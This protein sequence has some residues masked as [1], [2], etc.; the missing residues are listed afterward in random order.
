MVILDFEIDEEELKNSLEEGV[1]NEKTVCFVS[2]MF[3]MPLRMRLNELEIFG[4]NEDYWSPGPIMDLATSGLTIIKELR[5][6]RKE[7]YE[8]IEG[9]GDFIFTMI[10]DED[11]YVKFS[12]ESGKKYATTV[13]YD[14]ILEAFEKFTEKVRKFLWERVPQINNHPYWGPWLRGDRE[15]K[16]GL[17]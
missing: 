4:T 15:W 11:V 7:D 10:S 1:E 2:T 13:K 16:R 17:A 12:S 14:E 5:E 6:N 9:P 8:I 3:L